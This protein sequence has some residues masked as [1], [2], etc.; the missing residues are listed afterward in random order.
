GLALLTRIAGV[1]LLPALA[2]IAWRSPDRRRA[3]AGLAIPAALFSAYPALLAV[4][5]GDGWAFLHSQGLWHR[6][7]SYAGPLGGVS[8]APR[9]GWA[10]IEQLA[11]G[12]HTHNYWPAVS[13]ADSDP[14]RT[15]LINLSALL[16]LVLF[17]WLSVIAWRRFGAVYGLYC[18]VGL[19]IPLCAPSSRW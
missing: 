15:A 19:A 1:A 10:G 8:D 14:M 17:L 7:F 4:H 13:I 16:F 9:A 5:L 18:L 6:H 3:L 2:L 12:S 11:S